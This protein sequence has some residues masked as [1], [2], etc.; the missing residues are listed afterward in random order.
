MVVYSSLAASDLPDSPR[1]RRLVVGELTLQCVIKP[2]LRPS[3]ITAKPAL[4]A[5]NDFSTTWHSRV[6]SP[7]LM[8]VWGSK[9]QK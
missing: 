1:P 4:E 5:A 2:S 3:V 9:D 7:G 6:S 8:T